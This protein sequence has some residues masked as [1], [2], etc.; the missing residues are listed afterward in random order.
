[1]E[2]EVGSITMASSDMYVGKRESSGEKV[3]DVESYMAC[4]DGGDNGGNEEV[5]CEAFEVCPGLR[6]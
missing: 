3:I 4:K 6:C 5:V 2:A 1:V